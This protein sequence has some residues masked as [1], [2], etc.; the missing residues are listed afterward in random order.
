MTLGY[1]GG[2][3]RD[4]PT[5]GWVMSDLPC[6]ACGQNLRSLHVA[7]RC[8]GCGVPV[9]CT[10][11]P[12]VLRFAR[13]EWLKRV[14]AGLRLQF[15]ALIVLSVLAVLLVAGVSVWGIRQAQAAAAGTGPGAAAVVVP[16]QEPFPPWAGGVVAFLGVAVVAVGVWRST[17]P[18]P[19]VVASPG[20]GNASGPAP[21][22]GVDRWWFPRRLTRACAVGFLACIAVD[23]ILSAARTEWFESPAVTAVFEAVSSVLYV[24]WAAMATY[25]AALAARLPDTGLAGRSRVVAWGGGIT[26]VLLVLLSLVIGSFQTD[27]ENQA[28]ATAMPPVT[29]MVSGCFAA[30]VGLAM[31]GFFVFHLVTLWQLTGGVARAVE[32]AEQAWSAPVAAP[33]S[34]HAAGST[35]PWTPAVPS[36]TTAPPELGPPASPSDPPPGR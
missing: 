27:I 34:S 12:N 4:D 13:P 36:A 10:A 14:R 6:R 18:E 28:G 19:A 20:G 5:A 23:T 32:E 31:L 9:G 30:V 8:P 26:G 1:F 11:E 17:A 29:L 21:S 3:G 33:G 16:D 25:G 35:G 15:W 22:V 7:A 24:G 2:V